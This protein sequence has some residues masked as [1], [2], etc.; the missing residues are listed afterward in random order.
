MSRE[1]IRFTS[2]FTQ[3]QVFDGFM[4]FWQSEGFSGH[5]EN[6]EQCMKKGS[7]IATGPQFVKISAMNGMYTL[8]AWIKF[9]VLPGVYAGEMDLKGATGAIPKKKLKG[10][11]DAF[12]QGVQA[13]LIY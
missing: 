1:I 3:Q 4:Q 7:G 6:G 5:I 8:E 13:Q 11:V 10:R 2:P 9:A 12:L